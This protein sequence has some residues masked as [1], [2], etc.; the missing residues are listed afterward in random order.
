MKRFKEVKK[1]QVKQRFDFD[2]SYLPC[3]ISAKEKYRME[4]DGV[5]ACA[6]NE[7]TSLAAMTVILFALLLLLTNK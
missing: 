4:V 5:T 3:G 7:L 1:I 6:G 2:I